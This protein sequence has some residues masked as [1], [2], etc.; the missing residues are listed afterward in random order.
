MARQGR[1]L[2]D[3]FVAV[4]IVVS[5]LVPMRL[6][7][8]GYTVGYYLPFLAFLVLILSNARIE[9]KG[10]LDKKAPII[11]VLII[12]AVF[13]V[14]GDTG[15]FYSFL[16]PRTMLLIC[17]Y[18]FVSS[19][20]RFFALI[21]TAVVSLAVLGLLTV[22]ESVLSFN[23]FDAL[24]NDYVQYEAANAFRLALRVLVAC[25]Q[26]LLTS[27]HTCFLVQCLPFIGLCMPKKGVFGL[28]AM[29]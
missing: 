7:F 4:L 21:E 20:V 2:G 1:N 5:A 6:Q 12:S 26:F 18:I 24:C 28:H 22:V 19:R 13:L 11:S 23:V 3:Y 9:F 16:F 14:N 27:V 10:L 17:S 15:D 8:M 29:P 25:R